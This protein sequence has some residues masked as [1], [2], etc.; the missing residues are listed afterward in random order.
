MYFAYVYRDRIVFR[1]L[2]CCITPNDAI[3][4]SISHRDDLKTRV[5]SK[6]PLGEYVGILYDVAGCL[7]VNKRMVQCLLEYVQSV[8]GHLHHLRM[9]GDVHACSASTLTATTG[10]GAVVIDNSVVLPAELL[11]LLGKHI[12]QV[13]TNIYIL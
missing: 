2:G 13:V 12:P 6:T 11:V 9:S 5:G 1:L 7:L 3:T 10:V 8:S 4:Q